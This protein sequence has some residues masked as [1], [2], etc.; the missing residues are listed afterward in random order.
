M[1]ANSGGHLKG[2]VCMDGAWLGSV[3]MAQRTAGTW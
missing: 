1:G 2:F 3:D